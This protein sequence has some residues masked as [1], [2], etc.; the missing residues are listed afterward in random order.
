MSSS[1]KEAFPGKCQ[2]LRW[3]LIGGQGGGLTYRY[4]HRVPVPSDRSVG[5]IDKRGGLPRNLPSQDYKTHNTFYDL[6]V[7]ILVLALF[8]SCHPW[9]LK[10]VTVS[11]H[12]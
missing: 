5:G 1:D 10:S 11:D 2:G 8:R 3:I 6:M 7:G 12:P 4:Q 9:S